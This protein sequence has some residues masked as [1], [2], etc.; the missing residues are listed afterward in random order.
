M[1]NELLSQQEISAARLEI[2]NIIFEEKDEIQ[3]QLLKDL[4]LRVVEFA[5]ASI[6][7]EYRQSLGKQFGAAERI[8]LEGILEKVNGLS[9]RSQGIKLLSALPR[10]YPELNFKGISQII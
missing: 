8:G 5:K 10:A 6:N 2:Q 9:D 4:L 1:N 3:K 7:P